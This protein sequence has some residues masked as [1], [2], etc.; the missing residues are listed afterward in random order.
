VWEIIYNHSSG[1][2]QKQTALAT[3]IM[4]TCRP[5]RMLCICHSLP[6]QHGRTCTLVDSLLWRLTTSKHVTHGV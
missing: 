5:T 4:H 3:A 2:M 6:R 1:R